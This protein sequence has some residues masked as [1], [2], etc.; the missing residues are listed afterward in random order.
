MDVAGSDSHSGSS[1]WTSRGSFPIHALL[2]ISH[3]GQP[4]ADTPEPGA[5]QPPG[6]YIKA[7]YKGGT[8]GR[9]QGRGPR[10]DPP[11]FPSGRR[12]GAAAA[13]PGGVTSAEARARKEGKEEKKKS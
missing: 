1:A 8:P 5:F 7:L 4:M 10:R 3:L 9:G 12:W 11:P 6:A 13:V 2:S